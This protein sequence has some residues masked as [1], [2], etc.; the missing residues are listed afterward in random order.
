MIGGRK[1]RAGSGGSEACGD[2]QAEAEERARQAAAAEA[3]RLR[4]IAR[5][6]PSAATARAARRRKCKWRCVNRS[7]GGAAKEFKRED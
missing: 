6:S 3:E 4:L 7:L 5:R 1:A 2:R